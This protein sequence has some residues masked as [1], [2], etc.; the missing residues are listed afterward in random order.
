MPS[1][2]GIVAGDCRQPVRGVIKFVRRRGRKA[3]SG[4]S[5]GHVMPRSFPVGVRLSLAGRGRQGAL[6]VSRHTAV[7]HGCLIGAVS[8]I[9]IEASKWEIRVLSNTA[10]LSLHAS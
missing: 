10:R 5:L 4:T 9:N 8:G 6:A 2:R 3:A 7:M 1:L